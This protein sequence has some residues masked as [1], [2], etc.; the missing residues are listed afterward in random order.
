MPRP[1]PSKKTVSGE[2]TA[3]APQSPPSSAPA[4]LK[5]QRWAHSAQVFVVKHPIP[6]MAG[7]ALVI[8]LVAFHVNRSIGAANLQVKMQHGFRSAEVSVWVDDQLTYTGKTSAKK[9]RLHMLPAT[10]QGTL[11]R[12]IQVPAGS[13]E[14]RVRVHSS[15][16]YDSTG[17]ITG[18]FARN[19][20][21][22][23]LIAAGKPGNDLAL[24]WVN[25]AGLTAELGPVW[26]VKYAG[27]LLMTI[28]GS[29]ISA[30][31][32]FVIRELPNIARRSS[33]QTKA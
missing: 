31:T 4:S 19:A 5:L 32:A 17:R 26:Y 2:S 23:L 33:E 27:S 28:A 3:S 8:F 20:D 15:D 14:L 13:H 30:C 22:G 16:G 18:D 6:F 1:V 7:L 29:I 25:G 9:R 24:S 11:V 10:V 21:M 12:T